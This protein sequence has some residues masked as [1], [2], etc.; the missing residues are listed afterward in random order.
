VRDECDAGVVAA[1]DHRAISRMGT[2]NGFFMVSQCDKFSSGLGRVMFKAE[3]Q[4]R[5]NAAF[6]STCLYSMKEPFG[7]DLIVEL[8]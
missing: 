2:I 1:H 6:A 5:L 4:M 8:S 7:V 3:Y